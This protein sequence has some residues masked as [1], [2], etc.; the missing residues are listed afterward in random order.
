MDVKSA[1]L[2]GNIEEEVCIEEHEGFQK[3][4]MSS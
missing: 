1:F 4:N 3:M 2:N